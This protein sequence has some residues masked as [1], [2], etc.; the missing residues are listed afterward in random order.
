M[1]W[2]SNA[3]PSKVITAEKVTVPGCRRSLKFA[4]FA[5][6]VKREVLERRTPGWVTVPGLTL[7][8]VVVGPGPLAEADEVITSG[9]RPASSSPMAASRTI[10]VLR[11]TT[12]CLGA[13]VLNHCPSA[14]EWRIVFGPSLA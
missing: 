4:V 3:W 1:L 14:T 6:S 8:V 9:L 5:Q 13:S 2:K 11:L 12:R 7:A 10:R